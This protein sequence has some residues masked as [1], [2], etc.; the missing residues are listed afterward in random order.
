MLVEE[1]TLMMVSALILE[2]CLTKV[3]STAQR[4]PKQ[5]MGTIWSRAPSITPRATPVR[6]LCPRASEKKAMRL[7]TAMVPSIPNRGVII[8]MAIS[9]LRM[10]L[11]CS[12]SNGTQFIPP[13]PPSNRTPAGRPPRR[14]PPGGVPGR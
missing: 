10:K 12:H 7:S 13:P 4:M 9:A 5:S 6:A 3:M 11:Y 8:S 2:W 14:R 1:N